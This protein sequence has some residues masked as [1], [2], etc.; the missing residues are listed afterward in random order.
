MEK[1]HKSY[2]MGLQKLDSYGKGMIYERCNISHEL[3]KSATYHQG[4]G[5]FTMKMCNLIAVHAHADGKLPIVHNTEKIYSS[6]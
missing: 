5:I 1:A 6:N 4:Y 2:F 3:C